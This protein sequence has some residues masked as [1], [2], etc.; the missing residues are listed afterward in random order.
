MVVVWIVFALLVKMVIPRDTRV[1]TMV[2]YWLT[3][4]VIM[5]GGIFALYRV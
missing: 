4:T 1:S 5:V 2:Y 3:A